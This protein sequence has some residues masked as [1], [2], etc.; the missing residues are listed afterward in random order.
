MK[1]LLITI[2]AVLLMG[3]WE[4]PPKNILET[5]ERGSV[6]WVK[7]F[8]ASGMDVNALKPEPHSNGGGRVP[9]TNEHESFTAALKVGN[10]ETHLHGAATFG[11]KEVVKLL[12]TEGTDVNSKDVA[13]FSPLHHAE[14]KQIARL[15]IAR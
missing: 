13:G 3:C 6:K 5:T 14:T 12:I 15:L 2:A 1:Q 9:R 4:S 11:R 7:M 8:L 10:G